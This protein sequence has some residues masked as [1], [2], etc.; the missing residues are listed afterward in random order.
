MLKK[1]GEKCKKKNIPVIKI[2]TNKKFVIA[3]WAVLLVSITFAIYKNFTSIDKHTIHEKEI[4]EQKIIDTNGIENFVRNFAKDYYLWENNKKSIEKRTSKINEYLTKELQELNK[5]TIR[6]DIPTSSSV[7][8]I[9][10]WNVNKIKE[11]EFE[12]KYSV[13]QTIKEG[14][15]IKDINSYYEI[16]VKTDNIG[17][18]IIIKNPTLSNMPKKLNY[19]PKKEETDNTINQNTIKEIT[20]FLNTFFKL[21]PNA[22][23]NELEYYVKD[24]ALKPINGQYIFSELVNPI[25]MK[26]GKNIKVAT[27]VKYIDKQTKVIQIS[28]YNLTLEKDG[29]WVIIK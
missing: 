26:Y 8:E 20:E 16:V 17:N 15:K 6:N 12:V 24:D 11:N 7:K 29:N 22:T 18:M 9:Q 21:Y 28:Q 25:F 5:D 10:I 19:E 13:E 4:I 14:E 23:K 1:K 2:G 3:L 27:R